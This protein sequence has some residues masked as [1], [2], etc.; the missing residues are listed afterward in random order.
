MFTAGAP[1]LSAHPAAVVQGPQPTVTAVDEQAVTV[2]LCAFLCLHRIFMGSHTQT[3]D[4]LLQLPLCLLLQ[5][6]SKF[7]SEG[8]G[9][10]KQSHVDSCNSAGLCGCVHADCQQCFIAILPRV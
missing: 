9:N 2:M 6:L 10:V 7:A 1:E 8:F 5:L 4:C 3:L